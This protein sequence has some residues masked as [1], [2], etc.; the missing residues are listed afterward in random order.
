M[1]I[2]ERLNTDALG[3]LNFNP[4]LRG[5]DPQTF[6]LHVEFMHSHGSP[7]GEITTFFSPGTLG[8]VSRLWRDGADRR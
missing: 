3:R 1:F 5:L 4:V 6:K 8:A 2:P 7:R